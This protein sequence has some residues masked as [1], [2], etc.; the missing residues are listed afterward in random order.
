MH[1]TVG[2]ILQVSF[3]ITI[4][5]PPPPLKRFLRF[6]MT[7]QCLPMVWYNK[8]TV[9]G[10]S[11]DTITLTR[12]CS[13]ILSKALH[14][15]GKLGPAE[16]WPGLVRFL[17]VHSGQLKV[18]FLSWFLSSNFSKRIWRNPRVITASRSHISLSH[19]FEQQMTTSVFY[20]SNLLFFLFIVFI[21]CR[22]KHA[23][24]TTNQQ[25]GLMKFY[26]SKFFTLV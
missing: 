16:F 6:L 1:Y 15:E 22:Y 5:P 24:L 17:W 2:G 13:L 21:I 4:I 3:D 10:V 20:P 26:L 8:S 7:Q 25:L 12:R 23:I 9:T 11:T 19:L 18:D 14:R